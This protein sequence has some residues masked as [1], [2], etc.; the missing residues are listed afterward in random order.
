MWWWGDVM[1]QEKFCRLERG[2]QIAHDYGKV[3][4]EEPCGSSTRL[5]IGASSGQTE[6]LT[7]LAMELAGHPWFVLYVLLVPR[8]GNRAPGRYQS[9]PFETHAELASFLSAFRAFF[10]GDGRHHVW[11]GSVPNDGM[12][13]Y[14][15]HNVIFAYGPIAGFR[16][17]L[18]AEGY[19]ESPFW[20]PAPHCHAFVAENDSEEERLM[21][22]REWKYSPL[23]PGD[24]W[25]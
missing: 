19:R 18:T 9:D 10:E 20:F 11:I 23:R 2:E 25:E 13:V 5:V 16:A 22:E 17:I 24:E 8:L 12:L 3:F 14:D 15:H 4:F 7:E 1:F 6:L 21:A